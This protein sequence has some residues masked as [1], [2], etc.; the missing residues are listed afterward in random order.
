[1]LLLWGADRLIAKPF[2]GRRRHQTHL[3]GQESSDSLGRGAFCPALCNLTEWRLLRKVLASAGVD[4]WNIILK[5]KPLHNNY[6]NAKAKTANEGGPSK[7][8]YTSGSTISSNSNRKAACFWSA[9]TRMQRKMS[10]KRVAIQG[11][12]R[13]RWG[14][15]LRFYLGRWSWPVADLK[16]NGGYIGRNMNQFK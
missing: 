16:S 2:L 8:L 7:W 13:T 14:V 9:D 15:G 4:M 11:E 3:C 5:A 12:G 1:M 10:P 6:S